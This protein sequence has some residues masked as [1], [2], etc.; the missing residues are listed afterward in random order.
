MASQDSLRP[1]DV[2]V[3]L[4]LALHPEDRFEAMAEALG[5]GVGSAHRSVKRLSAAELLMPH[6]RA[7]NRKPLLD[8]LIHGV[9]YAFYPTL[10]PEAPGVPTAHSAPPL[11]D[12]L[13]EHQTVVWPSSRGAAR[14]ESLIP[15]YEGAVDLPQ[16][17]RPLYELLTLVDALRIGRAR[18][19]RI[20]GNILEHRIRSVEE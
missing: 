8:F 16:R 17:D 7:A 4:R 20:A 13:S 10:G 6:R 19:R 14:G 2:A 15:L 9:R 11:A 5:I 18:E 12:Q 1:V 3:A